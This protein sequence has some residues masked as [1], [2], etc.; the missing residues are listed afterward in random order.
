MTFDLVWNVWKEPQACGIMGHLMVVEGVT[1]FQKFGNVDME[2]SCDKPP[3]WTI[4]YIIWM[5]IG[6]I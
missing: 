4:C 5:I 3:N 1:Y 2:Y 6:F